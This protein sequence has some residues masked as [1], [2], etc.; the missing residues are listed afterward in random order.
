MQKGFESLAPKIKKKLRPAHDFPHTNPKNIR[1]NLSWLKR[2]SSYIG[3][4]D[5][6]ELKKD[7]LE[8]IALLHI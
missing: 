7:L 8:K 4:M 3:A 5:N 2:L 1:S 6:T